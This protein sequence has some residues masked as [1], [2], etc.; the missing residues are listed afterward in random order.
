MTIR[1]V[2]MGYWDCRRKKV[3][4]KRSEGKGK[5]ISKRGQLVR[6]ERATSTTW[7]PGFF[8]NIISA[9]QSEV[10]SPFSTESAITTNLQCS[11][12]KSVRNDDCKHEHKLWITFSRYSW[13]CSGSYLGK[14]LRSLKERQ[15]HRLVEIEPM[16]LNNLRN[17]ELTFWL[18]SCKVEIEYL[19]NDI[20]NV[21]LR[22][23][24][25]TERKGRG[26]W[27]RSEK[28]GKNRNM[29]RREWDTYLSWSTLEGF[30]SKSRQNQM[31]GQIWKGNEVRWMKD[32]ETCWTFRSKDTQRIQW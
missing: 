10:P 29:R 13:W 22:T 27:E 32:F 18:V 8:P 26:R 14:G 16:S 19:A 30:K 2:Q 17:L 21:D 15:I 31:V 7:P 25:G 20:R 23:W 6:N 1:R 3:E 11:K 5:K 4:V 24:L 9:T 28:E 12:H